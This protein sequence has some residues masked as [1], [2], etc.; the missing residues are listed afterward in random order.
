MLHQT[1]PV[2]KLYILSGFAVRVRFESSVA[3]FVFLISG[4][5]AANLPD[6]TLLL[7]LDLGLTSGRV[8][9]AAIA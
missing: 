3:H 6:V 1:E 2:G 9:E 7:V 4:E 8:P 5:T